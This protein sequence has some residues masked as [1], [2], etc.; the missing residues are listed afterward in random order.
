MPHYRDGMRLFFTPGGDN[1]YGQ[2]DMHE[3]IP[4]NYW[5]YYF[6]SSDIIFYPSCAGLSAKWIT[7]IRVYSVPQGDWTL[8]LDGSDIGG[9]EYEISKT[10]FEQASP[11]SSA[12]ITRQHTPIPKGGSGKACPVAFRWIRRR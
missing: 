11:V 7:E 10:Y 4:E 12:P 9:M 8:K 2:W 1:V 3:T 6:S 5:H